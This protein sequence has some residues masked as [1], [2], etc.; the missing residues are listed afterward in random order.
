MPPKQN[1]W[2]QSPWKTRSENTFAR[3]SGK[4]GGLSP[5]PT[6]RPHVWEL[7][8]L[9]FISECKNSAFHAANEISL[10]R[11]RIETTR[12]LTL[13]IAIGLINPLVIERTSARISCPPCTGLFCYS[14]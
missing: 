11:N 10:P 14:N 1:P 4:A 13:Q 7:R 8:G 5:V 6:G 2:D 12:G 9:L 3:F